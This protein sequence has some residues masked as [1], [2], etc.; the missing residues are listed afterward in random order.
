M[1]PN[2]HAHSFQQGRLRHHVKNTDSYQFFNLLTS[3]EL[4]DKVESLLPE[5]RERIF[6]PTETLSMF[7]AQAMSADRSCQN[8]VND[9]SVKRLL[10]GLPHCSTYTG[11]YCKARKRLP[12][13]M[14]SSLSRYTGLLASKQAPAKWHWRNRPVRLVDG[15]T[16]SM[17]DT[18]DNQAEYPQ[19]SSQEAGLGFPLCRIVGL[20]CLGSGGILDAAVCPNKGKG[21]DEQS[22]LRS[23]LHHLQGGD[24]LIGDAYYATY[25]L[26]CSLINKGV[27]AVFEQHGSRRR[28]VDF[29][30]GTVLGKRDHL[31][32]IAK[33]KVCPV[34]MS[35]EE[36]RQAPDSI[37]IRELKTGGKVLVTTLLCSKEVS[38]ADLKAL[39]H[40]R[41][42]VELDLRNIKTTLGMEVLSC[43]TPEMIQKEI[44]VYLL[45][46]NLI[47]LLMCQS[48]LLADIV[49][50]EISFKH[51]V[52]IWL[53]SVHYQMVNGDE[54]IELIL[55]LI[56][57]QRVGN[58]PGRIEPR[59]VKRRPK[60]YSKLRKPRAIAKELVRLNG[61]PK[62]LK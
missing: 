20:I 40:Q 39:Y 43:R 7:L 29:T 62:K 1:H 2:Q 26:F 52:Q 45:A 25:F 58:R 60:Q 56:A 14:V 41:W 6:P 46:Y 44:W 22:L 12:K 54:Y 16:L 49:P 4:I 37:Q 42:H 23:M 34:W 24:L 9:S 32:T 59:V 55:L 61:H 38:K 10:S 50:R 30:Q 31:I 21:N 11:A 36:Y 47:R 8:A 57:Q 28:N 19:P 53:A 48:A 13:Q 35:P 51:A 18:A 33:P 17:P 5:H 3:T 15:S 27:D